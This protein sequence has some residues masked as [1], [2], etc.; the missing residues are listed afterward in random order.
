[1]LIT[2]H[3][4]PFIF[5]IAITLKCQDKSIK[6]S[7]RKS[8]NS[9]INYKKINIIR[10]NTSSISSTLCKTHFNN[11]TS[12]SFKMLIKTSHSPKTHSKNKITI[13]TIFKM[14][15]QKENTKSLTKISIL[16]NSSTKNKS[17]SN[18]FSNYNPNT[19]IPP[20]PNTANLYQQPE[21]NANSKTLKYK[22]WSK[23]LKNKTFLSI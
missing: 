5:F 14:T 21:S 4:L 9:N 15:I 7:T 23:I 22:K 10:F 17:K 6:P 18:T 8:P 12:L 1:M 16:K 20:N 2:L 19:R 3:R 11:L 13:S